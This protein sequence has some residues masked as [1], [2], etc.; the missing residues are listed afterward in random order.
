MKTL[1]AIFENSFKICSK[2]LERVPEKTVAYIVGSFKPPHAGHYNMAKE[3]AKFADKIVIL[4]DNP[5]SKFKKMSNEKTI[6][7]EDS[8]KIWKMFLEDGN[9]GV[10]SDIVLL[11]KSGG[12]SE[13][14]F[15]KITELAEKEA[16]NVGKLTV[17]FG[18]SDKDLEKASDQFT[19]VFNSLK[20][21][22]NIEVRSPEST[23]IKSEKLE[24]N[25]N[26]ISATELREHPDNMDLLRRSMPNEL[27][28]EHF[29]EIYRI[30]NPEKTV[31]N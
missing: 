14:Q 10:E 19:T 1:K 2:D 26:Q 29:N 8:V 23:A 20:N 25:D 12:Y 31:T 3:Y 24:K 22:D 4:V 17:I 16:E 27:T 18:I 6:T 9:F 11:D 28:D 21:R 15:E 30:L 7:P 13:N 5:K